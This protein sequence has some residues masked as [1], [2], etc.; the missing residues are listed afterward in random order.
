M[1]VCFNPHYPGNPYQ[2]IIAEALEVHDVKVDYKLNTPYD[3]LH[4]HWQDKWLGKQLPKGRKVWTC[5]NLLPHNGGRMADM[6]AFAKQMDAV[7]CHTHLMRQKLKLLLGVDA[8]VIP[9]PHYKGYY[10][11]DMTREEARAMLGFREEEEVWL[12]FGAIKPYKR[13]DRAIQQFSELRGENR[14]L[15]IAGKVHG[16]NERNLIALARK[17]KR[18][19]LLPGFV[20]DDKVQQ[21]FTA[22]DVQVLAYDAITTSGSAMLGLSYNLPIV[23][24]ALQEVRSQVPQGIFYKRHLKE[25]LPQLE[26]VIKRQSI[27][28]GSEHDPEQI[29]QKTYQVYKKIMEAKQ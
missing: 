26:R 27:T 20:P 5:H 25:V 10:A 13:V 11:N 14:R 22:A 23:A 17:D 24:P 1:R 4:I 6:R 3:I 18:I 21:L 15:L 7:I 9:H 2:Q 12:Q 19:K 28:L 8:V 16:V 29:G